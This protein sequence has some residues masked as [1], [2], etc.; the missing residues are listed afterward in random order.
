MKY[1][2]IEDDKNIIKILSK[3]IQE[4]NLGELIGHSSDGNSAVEDVKALKPDIVLVDLF[5]PGKNGI[6]VVSELNELPNPTLFVMISQVSN[7]DMIA[8]AYESGIEFYI[9][10]PI[11][12]IEVENVLKR[13]VAYRKKAEKLDHIQKIFEVE[14]ADASENYGS[15]QNRNVNVENKIKSILQKIGVI[16]ESG[17][18]D[19]IDIVGFLVTSKTD[20]SSYTI[21]EICA[22]FG[23]NSKSVEQRIR[24]TAAVGLTNL[25]HLGIEDYMNDTFLEYSNGLYNFSEVKYEMDYIRGK[26]KNRGK[27]SIRKFIDGL[28]IYCD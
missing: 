8:R 6:K 5:I 28:I 22:R 27:V 20:L 25:A 3:I 23:Y 15:K 26:V 21:K 14:K 4:R 10:K 7:K 17:T 9:Q 19:I 24:R 16:G 18:Q 13:V 2:I 12:A 1:F 11:N